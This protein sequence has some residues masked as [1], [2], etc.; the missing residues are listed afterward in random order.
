MTSVY[1]CFPDRQKDRKRV[2]LLR[3]IPS[4]MLQ[5]IR[6]VNARLFAERARPLRFLLVGGVCGVLQLGLLALL[7]LSGWEAILA[8]CVG[9]LLAAQVNFT[10]STIFTWHDRSLA[11]KMRM[12]LPWRWLHFHGT[13]AATA[14]LNQGIF[15]MAQV[16]L[17]A[18]LASALGIGVASI[19][20]FVLGDGLVFRAE[21]RQACPGNSVQEKSEKGYMSV[22]MPTVEASSLPLDSPTYSIIAPI[23]N[24]AETLPHFYERVI[25]VMERVGEPFELLFINDGSQ[26]GSSRFLD[27]LHQQDERVRVVEFSRN[28]GHEQ[29]ILA[30]LRYA[31]GRAVIM[32]DADLQDPPEVIPRLII[33][34]KQGGEVVYARREKRRGETAFKLFTAKVFYQV[35]AR[36]T[37]V[38][39]PQNTGNFRLLD[40][41]VV[42]VLVAMPE[43]HRFVRGLSTWVGFRQIAVPY[44]RDERLAGTTKYPLRKMLALS[45]D[46]I[47]SF[48]YL[49]LR[50]ATTCGFV[51]ATFSL[52]GIVVAMVARLTTSAIVGQATTLALVLFL[53]GVQLLFLGILGEY[54]ARIYD[55]VRARPLY[56]VRNVLENH[57]EQ[58][59]PVTV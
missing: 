6:S 33:A 27:D 55:E 35:L 42:D 47:T 53:G 57:A 38:P 31:R 14:L 24:E 41:Q 22:K 10:L 28:F 36:L 59:S 20:N 9:F 26:D 8:N 5:L 49:P 51:L 13:I 21:D 43:R 19:A 7:T 56:I 29:A 39:I 54:L 46:A 16:L 23:Y 11:S 45:F 44:E 15:V 30:G 50:L 18:L 3:C 34:W 17:P 37:S 25:Q 52:L 40:R 2:N 58:K 12:A 1:W 4:K 32:L 48:S